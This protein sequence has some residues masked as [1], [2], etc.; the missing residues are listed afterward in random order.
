MDNDSIEIIDI[1]NALN[2]NYQLEDWRIEKY[3]YY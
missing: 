2:S 1:D 3:E